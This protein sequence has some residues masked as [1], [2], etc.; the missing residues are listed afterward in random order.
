MKKW[1]HFS[2]YKMSS[3]NS[4]KCFNRKIKY[5]GAEL[6]SFQKPT[7]QNR[8]GSSGRDLLRDRIVMGRDIGSLVFSTNVCT[9]V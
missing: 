2:T 6:D 3:A 9:K 4:A 1:G 5:I 8:V 7:N